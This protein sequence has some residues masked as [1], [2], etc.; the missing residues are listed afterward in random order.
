MTTSA[1]EI[2]PLPQCSGVRARGI[3]DDAWDQGSPHWL[4]ASVWAAQEAACHRRDSLPPTP[5]PRRC[6]ACVR[7]VTDPQ[8]GGHCTKCKQV[9]ANRGEAS[10]IAACLTV[11]RTFATKQ[12]YFC[13]RDCQQKAWPVHKQACQLPAERQ[14]DLELKVPA[15]HTALSR[16]IS[17]T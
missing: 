10:F 2:S 1:S 4:P 15:S 8:T 14:L 13:S 17:K 12:V 11:L 9:T 16:I 5:H 6:A 7:T 3:P